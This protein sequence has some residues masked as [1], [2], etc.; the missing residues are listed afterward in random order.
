MSGIRQQREQ[1]VGFGG[2]GGSEDGRDGVQP[3]MAAVDERVDDRVAFGPRT[4]DWP[5]TLGVTE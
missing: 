2:R 3:R 1:L 5:G 4:E